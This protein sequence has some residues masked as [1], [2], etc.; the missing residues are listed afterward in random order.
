MIK[1]SKLAKGSEEAKE[2]GKKMSALR[3]EKRGVKILDVP[4]QAMTYKGAMP[5]GNTA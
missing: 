5:A 4:K 3:K 1:T 2:W